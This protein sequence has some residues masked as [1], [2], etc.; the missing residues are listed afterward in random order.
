MESRSKDIQ[1]DKWKERERKEVL[2]RV[3]QKERK[4]TQTDANLP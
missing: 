4:N 3:M 2:G 1:T